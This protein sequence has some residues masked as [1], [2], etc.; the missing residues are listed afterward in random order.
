MTGAEIVN[1]INSYL[2]LKGISKTEFY[3]ACNITSASYSLW[4]TGKTKPRLNNLGVIADFLE[5]PL[6]E[7]TDELPTKEKKPAPIAESELNSNLIKL[8][9][10]LTPDEIKQVDAFVQGLIAARK[11]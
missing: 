11:A 8:L 7:L 10:K 5:I 3:K 4:N 2:A 9:V 6:S 1:K